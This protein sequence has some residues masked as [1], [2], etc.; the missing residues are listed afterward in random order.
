MRLIQYCT[1]IENREL[2]P[3]ARP[4][5][6]KQCIAGTVL[7]GQRGFGQV[8]AAEAM[9]YAIEQARAVGVS[10]VTLSNCYHSG[11]LA[12]YSLMAAREGMIGIVMVNAGG[13]GQSVTPFGGLGR[14]LATNP[15]AIA[16]PSQGDYFPVLDIATSMVPEGKIR[17][18]HRKSE[19]LPNGWI[20]DSLGRPSNDAADFYELPGGAVLPWGG[21]V[22][23]KGFGLALMIDVLA[24]ALSGAG[25][26]GP[27]TVPA[28]DGVLLLAIDIEQFTEMGAFHKQVTRLL[29][30]VKS[31]PPAPGFKEVFVPGE[32]EHRESLKRRRTGIQVDD[33]TWGEIQALVNRY[34]VDPAIYDGATGHA[35]DLQSATRGSGEE[36]AAS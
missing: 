7:D 27:E 22:G 5:V 15:F 10:A 25:C 3:R 17:D 31:C 35:V 12:V 6:R 2:D 4:S 1:A 36:A 24:G 23:Y 14:R 13:G 29:N 32:L 26:C 16:I 9:K 19:R 20:V 33:A 30:H 21:A 11:R 28:R 18:Y 34:G 8:A